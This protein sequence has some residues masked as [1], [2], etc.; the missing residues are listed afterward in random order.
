MPIIIP[1][2]KLLQENKTKKPSKKKN[3][4]NTLIKRYDIQSR[5]NNKKSVDKSENEP[6][7]H[8]RAILDTKMKTP[9]TPI[10]K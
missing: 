8:K 6:I 7:F 10:E 5:L 2:Q 9:T 3:G 4:V 1:L